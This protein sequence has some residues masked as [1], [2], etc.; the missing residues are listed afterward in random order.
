MNAQELAKE[1]EEQRGG[2]KKT[3]K[4]TDLMTRDPALDTILKYDYY[5]LSQDQANFTKTVINN[6]QKNPMITMVKKGG[7][8]F[9]YF[10]NITAYVGGQPTGNGVVPMPLQRKAPIYILKMSIPRLEVIYVANAT[11][12][13]PN[14]F[15]GHV[16]YDGKKFNAEPYFLVFGFESLYLLQYTSVYYSDPSQTPSS[17]RTGYASLDCLTGLPAL[18]T[19]LAPSENSNIY[20]LDDFGLMVTSTINGTIAINATN[21]YDSYSNNPN[22]KIIGIGNFLANKYGLTSSGVFAITSNF[23]LNSITMAGTVYIVSTQILFMPSSGQQYILILFAPRSDF[24]SKA[25]N[26][27]HNAIMVSLIIVAVGIILVGGMAHLGSLPL[28]RLAV[29]MEKV[30]VPLTTEFEK[31][32]DNSLLYFRTS[33]DQI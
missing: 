20:M 21:R 18:F 2:I 30:S 6:L 7:M 4:Q 32:D 33:V 29:S 13:I 23:T 19:S 9:M 17:L 16:V 11:F 24:Y 28:K 12:L 14:F 10:K 5:D 3:A 22:P 15:P 31:W 25:D 27:L 26:A 8:Y 1:N